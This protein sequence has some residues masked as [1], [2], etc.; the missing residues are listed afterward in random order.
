MKSVF[1][2]KKNYPKAIIVVVNHL[3]YIS[4]RRLQYKKKPAALNLRVLVTEMS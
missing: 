4:Q 3:M 2:T 1:L